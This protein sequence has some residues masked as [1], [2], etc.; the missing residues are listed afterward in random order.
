M[1]DEHPR[2]VREKRTLAAMIRLYCRQQHHTAQGLGP[3]CGE[4][5]DYARER[6]ERCPFGEGKAHS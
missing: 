3:E 5:L 1:S 2:L 6:L 4:L